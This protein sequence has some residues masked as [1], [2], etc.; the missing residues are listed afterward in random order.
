M[1]T[2][3]RH[4]ETSIARGEIGERSNERS[5]FVDN[6]ESK[7]YGV[8]VLYLLEYQTNLEWKRIILLLLAVRPANTFTFT[9]YSLP[10][11]FYLRAFQFQVHFGKFNLITISC[12]GR[13]V[14][15]LQKYNK[16]Y[17]LLV[18]YVLRCCSR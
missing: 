11:T 5:E 3:T 6:C 9:A 16:I 12:W 13:K 1:N 15:F 18:F 14:A 17:V 2:A 7:Q 4:F 10:L 8:Q